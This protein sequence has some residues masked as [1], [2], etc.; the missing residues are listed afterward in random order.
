MMNEVMSPQSAILSILEMEVMMHVMKES[1]KHEAG[2][3]A[4]QKAQ[5]EMQ[6]QPVSEHIPHTAHDRRNDEPRHRDQR[7]W[8]LVMFLVTDVGRRRALVID[9]AVKGIFQQAPA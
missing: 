8:H 3:H 5:D 4:C 2:Q 9:P 7:L 6:L 1:V